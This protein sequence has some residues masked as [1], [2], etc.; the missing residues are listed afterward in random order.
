M[1]KNI[2]KLTVAGALALGL[3]ACNDSKESKENKEVKD[4]FRSC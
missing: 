3:T 4:D 2:L 1:I